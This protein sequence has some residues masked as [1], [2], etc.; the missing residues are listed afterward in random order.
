MDVG[1]PQDF[2]LGTK[3]YL[4]HLRNSGRL[5]RRDPPGFIGNVLIVMNFKHCFILTHNIVL[6]S[7]YI[8]VHNFLGLRSILR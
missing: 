7:L 5:E 6:C 2:I 8:Y 3:L 4:E 1:R